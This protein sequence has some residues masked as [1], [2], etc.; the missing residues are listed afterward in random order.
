MNTRSNYFITEDNDGNMRAV[1]YQKLY[2][3]KSDDPDNPYFLCGMIAN[4]V[5]IIKKCVDKKSANREL[6][7]RCGVD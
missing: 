5:V 7:L 1:I 2:V 3:E 4:A 6:L